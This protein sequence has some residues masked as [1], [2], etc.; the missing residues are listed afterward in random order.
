MAFLICSGPRTSLGS[1]S[2]GDLPHAL[3][4]GG[5]LLGLLVWLLWSRTGSPTGGPHSIFTVFSVLTFLYCLFS[6]RPHG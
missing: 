5:D 3:D 6:A 2:E 4:D 1:A